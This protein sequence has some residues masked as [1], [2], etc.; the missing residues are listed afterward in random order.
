MRSFEPIKPELINMTKDREEEG[1]ESLM[2]LSL[3]DILSKHVPSYPQML[4]FINQNL[5]LP[6][7]IL[8][9]SGIDTV[10]NELSRNSALYLETTTFMDTL[11]LLDI[12]H[13]G[14]NGHG[15]FDL[16]NKSIEAN[17]RS[18]IGSNTLAMSK[19]E[20]RPGTLS[21]KDDDDVSVIYNEPAIMS[22]YI[23][24]LVCNLYN[25]ILIDED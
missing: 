7:S 19:V 13:Y 18:T 8:T 17:R 5:M 10:Y 11:S 9:P 23:F 22:I 16:F 1:P 4:L 25:I 12:L 21:R 3:L 15:V 20:K 6:S 2:D 14:G 24:S